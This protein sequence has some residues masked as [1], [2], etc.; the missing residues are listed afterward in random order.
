MPVFQTKMINK[1]SSVMKLSRELRCSLYQEV[2]L[3]ADLNFIWYLNLLCQT[4]FPVQNQKD[5]T[6]HQKTNS[7]RDM[8]MFREIWQPGNIPAR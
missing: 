1:I 8:T 5:A 3:Q 7:I 4:K 6:H 2:M